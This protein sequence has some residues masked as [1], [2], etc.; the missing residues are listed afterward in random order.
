MIEQL[1]KDATFMRIE[2][3]KQLEAAG[4]YQ[5]AQE[6][7]HTSVVHEFNAKLWKAIETESSVPNEVEPL[8]S[9]IATACSVLKWAFTQEYNA[10][11]IPQYCNS[12]RR[13]TNELQLTATEGM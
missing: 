1:L 2:I 6:L 3:I 5:L 8:A 10:W 7:T 12:V 11:M 13:H 4:S 9:S